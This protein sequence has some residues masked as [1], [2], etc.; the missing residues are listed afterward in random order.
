[1]ARRSFRFK[2][3]ISAIALLVAV[4]G[5]YGARKLQA[6]AADP[7][8]EKDCRAAEPERIDLERIKAIAP[9]ASLTWSQL[10]GSIND[11]SC[12]NRTEI[13]GIVAVRT[14]DDISRALQF[15]R[16]NKLVVTVAGKRHKIGRASCRERV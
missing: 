2:A 7:T 1:M 6:L 5:A 10:G 4:F 13:Y 15:A 3:G 11:A 9:L 16:D 8:A 12:L 14:I